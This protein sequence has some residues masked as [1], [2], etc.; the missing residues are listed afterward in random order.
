MVPFDIAEAET[1]LSEGAF[2]EFSGPPYATDKLTKYIMLFVLPALAGCCC[3]GDFLYGN[4]GSG[5]C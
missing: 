1:E 5:R 2:I 3:S 4:I